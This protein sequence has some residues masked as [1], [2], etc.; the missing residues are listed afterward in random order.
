MS[1]IQQRMEI[2][3][4]I[5][6]SSNER[7][8]SVNDLRNRYKGEHREDYAQ[9]TFKAAL[10]DLIEAKLIVLD[11]QGIRISPPEDKPIDRSAISL[12]EQKPADDK[13]ASW[14][15]NYRDT[16]GGPKMAILHL[17]AGAGE[18]GISR[19]EILT[20]L[21]KGVTISFLDKGSIL[22]EKTVQ[23]N[24]QK[25]Y[26]YLDMLEEG[27][28]DTPLVRCEAEPG[29][30]VYRLTD[31]GTQK[32]QSAKEHQFTIVSKTILP[33]DGP[34]VKRIIELKNSI[35][36]KLHE[37][38]DGQRLRDA[39]EQENAR[40]ELA[41]AGIL[42][43][44]AVRKLDASRYGQDK[45]MAEGKIISRLLAARVKAYLLDPDMPSDAPRHDEIFVENPYSLAKLS[46]EEIAQALTDIE[47]GKPV[48]SAIKEARAVV[49]TAVQRLSD[50]M[51]IQ[52][53]EKHAFG[54]KDWEDP[55]LGNHAQSPHC[56]IVDRGLMLTPF[57][58]PTQTPKGASTPPGGEKKPPEQKGQS[59]ATQ[60]HLQRSRSHTLAEQIQGRGN[61]LAPGSGWRRS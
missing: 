8:M 50:R 16:L 19:H 4:Q 31:A 13:P 41:E 54:T 10:N 23:L 53:A 35:L 11:K 33:N 39:G 20:L 38:P 49:K 57:W 44:L 34:A 30:V 15:D 22:H 46:G 37:R 47:N 28:N 25:I 14:V 21:Q 1:A 26:S 59:A 61:P 24:M 12:D 43:L 58:P 60:P 6:E 9:P 29:K 17:I 52:T 42:H 27:H 36:Q 56:Q 18:Q 40:V 45:D 3:L 32:Y 2:I 48:A 7:A 51:M 5:L 55:N